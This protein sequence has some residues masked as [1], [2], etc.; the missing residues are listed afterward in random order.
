[1]SITPFPRDTP[2]HPHLVNNYLIVPQDQAVGGYA[3]VWSYD[4]SDRSNPVLVDTLTTWGGEF[5]WSGSIAGNLLWLRYEHSYWNGSTT[6]DEDRVLSVDITDPTNLVANESMVVSGSSY[7][8]DVSAH[9]DLLLIPDGSGVDG[10]Q[11]FDTLSGT[12]L[13]T[14]SDPGGRLRYAWQHSMEIL[15]DQYRIVISS[16][17][18][19]AL[20]FLV[21]DVD[22]TGFEVVGYTDLPVLTDDGDT[23]TNGVTTTQYICVPDNCWNWID[24]GALPEGGDFGVVTPPTINA[25]AA[26]VN[27]DTGWYE[28][29][30]DYRVMQLVDFA[31]PEHP[32]LRGFITLRQ[33]IDA[34]VEPRN[35]YGYYDNTNPTDIPNFYTFHAG[36]W[37]G[38]LFYMATSDYTWMENFVI[39]CSDLDNPVVAACHETATYEDGPFYYNGH[40]AYAV[41]IEGTTM[42]IGGDS[43]AFDVV[44]G[45]YGAKTIVKYDVTDMLNPVLVDEIHWDGDQG[46]FT[47]I[48]IDGGVAYG[49]APGWPDHYDPGT[50]SPP[51][52]HAIDI[53]TWTVLDTIELG[54]VGSFFEGRKLGEGVL[55]GTELHVHGAANGGP[56]VHVIDI[57]DPSN[58]TVIAEY[59]YPGQWSSLTD[60]V[61][62]KVL[63]QATI[64]D[65][66][67][68]DPSIDAWDDSLGG[69][70]AGPAPDY[71]QSGQL[72]TVPGYPDYEGGQNSLGYRSLG[73]GEHVFTQ[74]YGTEGE[75]DY[76][77][78][79]WG[80]FVFKI[81]DTKPV[82]PNRW[83]HVGTAIMADFHNSDPA[84]ATDEPY[85]LMEYPSNAHVTNYDFAG[86]VSAATTTCPEA[87]FDKGTAYP[88]GGTL[89]GVDGTGTRLFFSDLSTGAIDEYDVAG[90]FVQNILPAPSISGLYAAVADDHLYYIDGNMYRV[91]LDGSGVATL[92]FDTGAVDQTWKAFAYSR[93]G[94]SI[95][96]VWN[97][98]YEIRAYQEDGSYLVVHDGSLGYV[99]Y[100]GW[101]NG[102][103][104]FARPADGSFDFYDLYAWDG[105]NAL[106]AGDLVAP[107]PDL[108][109][110]T[111]NVVDVSLFHANGTDV[112]MGG[113]EN[114]P[115]AQRRA[116]YWNWDGSAVTEVGTA[117]IVYDEI[118][119][120]VVSSSSTGECTD[121]LM[122]VT[123]DP[124][125]G[126]WLQWSWG[127]QATDG[128]SFFQCYESTTAESR[129]FQWDATVTSTPY[130]GRKVFYTNIQDNAIYS[131][132]Y[133]SMT[134][135]DT[136]DMGSWFYSYLADAGD[137]AS[138][139]YGWGMALAGTKLYFLVERS[140]IL[141]TS[142]PSGA[143]IW[144]F[145]TTNPDDPGTIVY[146]DDDELGTG[147]GT[148]R[149]H[150][151]YNPA[152]DRIYIAEGYGYSDTTPFVEYH[153]SLV[154]IDRT[155]WT[156]EE[157][158]TFSPA[159]TT[160]P[161]LAQYSIAL[162]GERLIWFMTFT[163]FNQAE[164]IHVYDTVTGATASVEMAPFDYVHDPYPMSHNSVLVWDE[165]EP[166]RFTFDGVEITSERF[167]AA[168][169]TETGPYWTS[170]YTPDGSGTAGETF[171]FG[172]DRLWV[173]N[174]SCA[175][176]GQYAYL[177]IHST[178]CG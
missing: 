50:G 79:I 18:N 142:R 139:R 147:S 78:T 21:L 76:D 172:D 77:R 35:W 12:I 175:D 84:W 89:T 62:G 5:R 44:G 112:R 69:V 113:W 73:D 45:Q 82:A 136:H 131:V 109:P 26:V 123:V 134:P 114:Y 135:A 4:V 96:W 49:V 152:D 13:Q 108:A 133:P 106:T 144:E 126:L 74:F 158:V 168:T 122:D 116:V 47:S 83:E 65:Y 163:T 101:A 51:C 132:N 9:G 23:Y 127:H 171:T 93:A 19:S 42:I 87:L 39:D 165:E 119:G 130:T 11:A 48:I 60:V 56:G 120:D 111:D 167:P 67:L 148:M 43:G 17:F 95:I 118:T 110:G 157:L 155:T 103:H 169:L 20:F 170:V 2:A 14:E 71:Y 105:V 81:G 162:T 145:D 59:G 97:N 61:D 141:A 138:Y 98:T 57:T 36:A 154:A 63:V 92:L 159:T 16:G 8:G 58:L 85:T 177:G 34:A 33:I 94:D 64:D 54:T 32:R 10:L 31:V 80:F 161:A 1:M 55:I 15:D 125:V 3:Q 129:I 25:V 91:P 160:P 178:P 40:S 121:V 115:S 100:V 24:R 53:A 75:P 174:T 70:V 102:T 124:Q 153:T 156:R 117:S 30:D 173:H 128:T 146:E 41:A 28:I 164:F 66:A 72:S 107:A 38:S 86:Q 166:I 22:E 37:S 150:M 7:F 46:R 6:V 104:Y 52:V 143:E 140:S 29:M 88:W 149:G 137:G 27:G 90:N 176:C 68:F 99:F 151:V